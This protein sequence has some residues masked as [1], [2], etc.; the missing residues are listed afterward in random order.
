[1]S[2]RMEPYV[3]Q[4]ITIPIE[5]AGRNYEA[6]LTGVGSIMAGTELPDG[7]TTHYEL[8]GQNITVEIPVDEANAAHLRNSRAVND[9]LEDDPGQLVA[10]LELRLPDKRVSESIE[11]G[12]YVGPRLRFDQHG[13][14]LE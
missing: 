4:P 1:M 9:T 7:R 3:P 12:S 8:P 5:F 13:R 6:K 2:E 11:S 14:L 10:V